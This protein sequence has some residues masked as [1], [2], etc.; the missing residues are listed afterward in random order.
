MRILYAAIDQ[1]VPGSHGGAVHVTSVAEG[2]AARG[3]EVHALVTLTGGA[4]PNGA[5]RWWPMQPPLGLRQLRALRAAAV[6][7]LARRLEPDVIM[8]RYYNFGGEALLAARRVNAF[9]VLEVNA[10]VIDYPGSPK[11][12]LDRWLLV[13]PM[14][15]WREWQCG[16][17]DLIVTPSAKILPSFV[18][19]GRVLQVEWGADTARFRPR[20]DAS[21][22]RP[23]GEIVVVFVGA[24]R[25]WHGAIDLVHA[26][27]Q[28]HER[29]RDVKALFVGD[30]PELPAAL[31]AAEG[32]ENVTFTGALSHQRVAEVLATADVGIAPFDVAHHPPLALEF[33]WSPLKVFEYM[34]AGLPVVA[35]RIARLESIVRDGQDGVLYEPADPHG[36]ATAIERLTDAAL[37]QTLG[38]SARDRVVQHFSWA[39]HCEQLDLAIQAGLDRRTSACVS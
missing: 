35:P 33:F 2:L 26:I 17:A 13:Q 14:R 3:H 11:G 28:L 23:S 38:R 21:R 12:T 18:P 29:G 4:G 34:A 30:G 25:A 39:R 5:V 24:F 19:P 8:E 1:A 20:S 15:R 36:L 31:K 9:S 7:K 37:R 6:V 22:P 16:A 27:R 10:P 32:L